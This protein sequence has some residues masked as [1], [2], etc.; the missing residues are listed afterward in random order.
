VVVG[1][2]TQM[3]RNS[4]HM[5]GVSWWRNLRTPPFRTGIHRAQR[6]FDGCWMLGCW[7]A[8]MLPAEQGYSRAVPLKWLPAFTEKAA[9]RITQLSTEW[10]AALQ[11][12]AW[13]LA[14]LARMGRALRN[15]IFGAARS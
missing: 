9:Y 5:E 1:D 7:D 15:A 3:P 12:L 6:W 2:A 14:Q 4:H 10:A 13:V 8:G 11:F